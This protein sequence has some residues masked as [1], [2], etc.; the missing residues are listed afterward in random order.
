MLLCVRQQRDQYEKGEG[1]RSLSC[2]LFARR[3][4]GHECGDPL[5]VF[6][7]LIPPALK[8]LHQAAVAG[9][10]N[11][12][13]ACAEAS[14]FSVSGDFCDD[15]VNIHEQC[16]DDWLSVVKD[17]YPLSSILAVRR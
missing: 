9:G 4:I 16:M 10:A 7:G 5:G 15:F 1:A 13:S 6:F 8:A 11:A 2:A 14:G 3:I 12:N 17:I